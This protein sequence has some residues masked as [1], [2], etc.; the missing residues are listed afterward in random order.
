MQEEGPGVPA[1]PKRK[2]R[3]IWTAVVALL[4]VVAFVVGALIASRTELFP[5]QVDAEAAVGGTATPSS[6]STQ[7][8]VAVWRGKF[9]S[10]TSQSYRE[11]VCRTIWT[12]SVSFDVTPEEAVDGTGE[13]ELVDATGCS[14][15]GQPQIEG[16]VF[17]V[18]GEL[19]GSRLRLSWNGFDRTGSGIVDSGG[20]A[21]TIADRGTTIALRAVPDAN[22][23][24]EFTRRASTAE[25]VDDAESV[26]TLTVGCVSNCG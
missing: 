15:S 18:G 20:F 22:V 12:G 2:R 3:W 26:T 6:P 13:A 9:R 24:Q 17:N 25:G 5:P 10:R 1:P 21:P 4:M 14:S 7:A 11:E 16:Y 19:V 8:G 23:V